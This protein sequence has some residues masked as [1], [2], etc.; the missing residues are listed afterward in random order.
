MVFSDADTLRHA[1]AGVKKR[2]ILGMAVESPVQGP[3]EQDTAKR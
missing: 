3:A 2:S 1:V